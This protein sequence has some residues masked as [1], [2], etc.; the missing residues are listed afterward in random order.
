M[1]TEQ[2]VILVVGGDHRDTIV[3]ELSARYARDYDLQTTTSLDDALD[4]AQELTITGR[5]IALLAVESV[6][7]DAT[8]ALALKVLHTTVPTARRLALVARDNWSTTVPALQAA[9]GRGGLDAYL[10]I[11]QGERDEEFHAAITEQLSEWAVTSSQQVLTAVTFVCEDS[12][13]KTARLRDFCERMGI[14]TRAV[15]VGTP[16]AAEVSVGVDPQTPLP[17]VRTWASEDV[18]SNPTTTDLGRLLYGSPSALDGETVDV[19]IVGAGPAGLAAAV[20]GA[21]EGLRTVVL[22]GDAIGGQ[23]GSSSMIRNYLGFPRGISGM[24][25][26]QRARTQALRFGATF[27]AGVPVTRLVPDLAPDGTLTHQ[28]EV[29][30]TVVRARTVVVATGVSY[31]RLGV[32]HVEEL[33][34]RGVSYGAAMSTAGEMA[35][36]DVYVVGGGNSAGQAAIHL[37][38]FARSVSIVIRRDSL[39]STMSSYLIKE[40]D[41]NPRISVLPRHE[42]VDAGGDPRLEWVE[43]RDNRDGATRRR[44]AAGL[45]L[46]LGAQ[47]HCEWVPTKIAT[48]DNGF[49]LTGGDTPDVCWRDGH[50]PEQL[51]TNLPGVYAVGDVRAGSMK[52]VASASGEGAA[53]IPLIHGY[54]ERSRPQDTPTDAALTAD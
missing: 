23:A 9:L 46:L 27:F 47:P 18:L 51:A 16:E 36:R 14:S 13:A 49:I 32:D 26:A 4:R 3:E 1:S 20:Y 22:E 40:I 52:R 17:W 21:S 43:L 7:P 38:R 35:G 19:A 37:A 2:P 6:L 31:R 29:D 10:L 48:D 41:G 34:G 11:P 42:V 24:R 8:G 15:I 39:D 28:L 5:Q 45:Y 53:V 50:P 33:V 25:L 30:G 54:L 12:C 44:P